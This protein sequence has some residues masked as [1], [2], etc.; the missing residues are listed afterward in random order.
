MA[1]VSMQTMPTCGIL[2]HGGSLSRPRG[3]KMDEINAV[4]SKVKRLAR[5]YYELTGRPLGVTG[6]V[7]EFVATELLGLER[8]KVRQ[9]G[10]DAVRRRGGR[11]TRIQ[12]K[13]RCLTDPAH[14]SQRLGSIRLDRKWDS[15]L[16]VL[17]DQWLEPLE[18]YEATRAS[19]RRQLLK[20]GSKSRN[21][22]GA[23][24]IGQFKRVAR[25]VWPRG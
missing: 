8:S 17:L 5:R 16:L 20:P 10:Y 6:E 14:R 24:S 9:S 11:V 13:A 4:L 2:A 12:I 19:V 23:L 21:E 25:R 22:R 3:F 18:L 15:V 1:V 7:A